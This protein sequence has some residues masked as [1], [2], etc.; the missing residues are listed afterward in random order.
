M[1]YL[2]QVKKIPIHFFPDLGRP[3]FYQFSQGDF[4]TRNCQWQLPLLLLPSRSNQW[5][6]QYQLGKMVKWYICYEY[7]FHNDDC[8]IYFKKRYLG[9][10][11]L[12]TSYHAAYLKLCLDSAI[13]SLS[14]YICGFAW[15]LG[16]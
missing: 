7:N 5:K 2:L 15:L 16:F 8:T 12:K 9:G 13:C 4:R 10:M 1:Y 11:T 3:G 6:N 14:V